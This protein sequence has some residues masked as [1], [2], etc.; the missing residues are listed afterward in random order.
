MANK[1]KSRLKEAKLPKLLEGQNLS[2][3]LFLL[4][5][6]MFLVV[7]ILEKKLKSAK[8]RKEQFTLVINHT[9][10]A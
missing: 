6:C 9:Q 10:A 1:F 3:E 2:N 4:Y 5:I 8:D 7:E